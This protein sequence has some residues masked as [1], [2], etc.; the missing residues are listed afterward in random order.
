[1]TADGLEELLVGRYELLGEIGTGGMGTVWRARS[2][3]TGEPVAVKVLHKNLSTDDGVVLRFVQERNVL[4]A[5]RHSHIVAVRDFVMGGDQL[6]LVMDLVDGR[7]LRALLRERG[8]LPPAEAVRLIGQ[9]AD[10]L[11]HAHAHGVVHRDV[12]PENVLID[13]AGQARLTDFG[14]ARLAHGPGLTQTSLILGTPSYLAPEVAD[15]QPATPAVDVYAT[16]LVLYELLA[17]RPPFVGDHPMAV[18]RQHAISAP[19]RL[20]GMPDAVWSMIITC[21]AKDPAQRPSIDHVAATAHALVPAL[22]GLPALPPISRSA[23]PA[24]TRE[25][26][27]PDVPTDMAATSP[28][29][30]PESRSR[31]RGRLIGA[32]AVTTALAASAAVALVANSSGETGLT[33]SAERAGTAPALAPPMTVRNTPP[34]PHTDATSSEESPSPK[35]KPKPKT[36]PGTS[37]IT[38]AEPAKKDKVTARPSPKPT[39]PKTEVAPETEGPA[40]APASEQPQPQWRCRSWISTGDGTGTQMSPC[41]ALVGDVFHL[42][43]RIRGVADVRS[44]V[45]VQLYNTDADS[46]VSPPMICTGLS[47]VG[48]G[49]VAT[50]GPFTI[51]AQHVG[52]K[53]NVRQRWRRT[54]TSAFGGGGESPWVFW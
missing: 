7:D 44:D 8:S 41:I 6:A 51:T 50:C 22:A 43:G 20:A 19:R 3:A 48:D 33:V 25:P 2:V 29:S 27:A 38:A 47:P 52:A 31:L 10:A 5:L 37:P 45:H 49:A 13:A 1:M 34:T 14:V 40:D 12:K 35:P 18:L 11:T 53:L 32:A 23:D 54:G 26:L 24:I 30:R 42:L 46:N 17:G 39:R 9:I 16:G 15:G 36:V 21:V 4:R 28:R